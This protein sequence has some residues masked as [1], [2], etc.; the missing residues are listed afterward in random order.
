MK[1]TVLRLL[2]RGGIFPL[3]FERSLLVAAAILAAAALASG[4]VLWSE[5]PSLLDGRLLA[6][7]T[8]LTIAVELGKASGLFDDLVASFAMSR[9]LPVSAALLVLLTAASLWLVS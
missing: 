8:I 5:V 3:A 4:R 7:L 2:R 6:L 1:R 9:F